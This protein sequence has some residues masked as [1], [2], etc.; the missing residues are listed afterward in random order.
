MVKKNKS[1]KMVNDIY[2]QWKKIIVRGK[3]LTTEDIQRAVDIAQKT[4]SGVDE[5]MLSPDSWNNVMDALNVT[6]QPSPDQ[7]FKDIIKQ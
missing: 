2:H 6:I 1:K 4:F 5:I 7:I 3:K